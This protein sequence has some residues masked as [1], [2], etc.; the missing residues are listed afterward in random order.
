[1]QSTFSWFIRLIEYKS[2]YLLLVLVCFGVEVSEVSSQTS[3]FQLLQSDSNRLVVSFQASP[4]LRS[5]SFTNRDQHGHLVALIGIPPAGSPTVSLIASSAFESTDQLDSVQIISISPI[6]FMQS[7]RIGRIS[8]DP[9]IQSAT[10]R[11]DLPTS[12]Y[13]V[14]NSTLVSPY[15]EDYLQSTLLN[16]D[17]ARKW[18]KPPVSLSSAPYAS[19]SDNQRFK[20]PIYQTGIYRI[21]S[22]DFKS[23]GIGLNEVDLKTLRM[24]S[25]ARAVGIYIFDLDKNDYFDEADF[26]VFLRS[27]VRK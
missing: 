6:G 16:Y 17:Q 19:T 4:S 24:S 22:E 25:G 21:V 20:I 11:I 5:S 14:D 13:S 23:V 2:P 26:I 8:V 1:M 10:F 9:R 12:N 18:R 15:I 27:K 3:N 7:Q